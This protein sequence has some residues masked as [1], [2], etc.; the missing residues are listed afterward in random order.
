MSPEGYEKRD[1]KNYLA[2][3]GSDCWFF[4][5]YMAGFGKTGVP[6]LCGVWR[7]SAFTIEVKRPGKEPTELQWRRIR[8]IR[9]AGGRAFWGTADKVIGEFKAWIS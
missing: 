1:I 7:G 6:D 3:L 2:S 9:A 5:P 4:S 8:E